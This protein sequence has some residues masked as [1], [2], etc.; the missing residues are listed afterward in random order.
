[1]KH[2]IQSASLL[3]SLTLTAVSENATASTPTMNP[4]SI[5]AQ[6]I[7]TIEPTNPESWEISF[8]SLSPVSLIGLPGETEE[9]LREPATAKFARKE[10]ALWIFVEVEDH[11]LYNN[12]TRFNDLIY[13]F[14][15]TIEVF[16]EV[17]E[18]ED[19]LEFHFSPENQRLQLY[20]DE[21]GR[22]RRMER[23][24]DLNKLYMEDPNILESFTDV[25]GKQWHLLI[26]IPLELLGIEPGS[27]ATIAASVCR[28]NYHTDETFTLSSTSPHTKPDFHQKSDWIKLSLPTPATEQ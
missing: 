13:R 7:A 24:L 10:E 8:E 5:E 16:L 27:A 3:S 12:S 1:M 11:H 26:K 19:Y 6:T 2:F 28:Y 22:T 17:N 20:W 4:T 14:G 25:D 9:A 18:S 15:D 23:R 21:D